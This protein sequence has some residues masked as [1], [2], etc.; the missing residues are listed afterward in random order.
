MQPE[1]VAEKI[2]KEVLKE[3]FYILPGSAKFL[4]RMKRLF[5]KLVFWVSDRDLKKARKRLSKSI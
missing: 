4:W 3:K 5:P 2:I 1:D